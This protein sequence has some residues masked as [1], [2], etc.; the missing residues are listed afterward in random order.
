MLVYRT[1]P[2]NLGKLYTRS[3]GTEITFTLK[4]GFQWFSTNQPPSLVRSIWVCC[5][6]PFSHFF[7]IVRDILSIKEHDPL[8][9]W[10]VETR[11]DSPQPLHALWEVQPRSSPH[12]ATVRGQLR[13]SFSAMVLMLLFNVS[14]LNLWCFYVFCWGQFCHELSLSVFGLNEGDNCWGG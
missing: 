9:R 7:S 4:S 1:K 10:L 3:D 11:K 14:F 12:V 6:L 2:H 13:H 8:P 5:K